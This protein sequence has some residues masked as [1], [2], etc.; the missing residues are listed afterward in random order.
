MTA[1]VPGPDGPRRPRARGRGP[2]DF[3][4]GP[5]LLAIGLVMVVLIGVVVVV[6]LL[7]LTVIPSDHPTPTRP[8]TPPVSAPPPAQ[9]APSASDTAL[10]TNTA[11]ARS[12][13]AGADRP[14]ARAAAARG[15]ATP[16]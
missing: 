14:R 11:L 8:K 1:P 12:H 4:G 10:E 7:A 15:I 2:R 13:R 6:G 3:R 16:S 9:Q 5:F